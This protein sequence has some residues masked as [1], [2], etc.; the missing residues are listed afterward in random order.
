MPGGTYSRSPP[1]FQVPEAVSAGDQETHFVLGVQLLDKR[2]PA[3]H[4]GRV[5][6]TRVTI[7]GLH[8][9]H[10]DVRGAAIGI[11][12]GNVVA[13]VRS[14]LSD[15]VTASR[16]G[17]V[18]QRSKIIATLGEFDTNEFRIVGEQPCVD[19][20]TVG[21]DLDQRHHTCP[22][23]AR[24]PISVASSH[25]TSKHLARSRA[26]TKRAPQGVMS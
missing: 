20:V 13:I 24:R 17:I 3:G 11:Q 18:G 1:R 4:L 25:I 9:R 19:N 12:F 14:D 22:P 21:Y 5:Q 15:R 6:P 7:V 26:C 10:V 8:S 2:L 16:A 23:V